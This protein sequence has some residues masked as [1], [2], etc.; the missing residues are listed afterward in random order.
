MKQLREAKQ[1]SQEAAAKRLGVSKNTIYRYEN[2]LQEPTRERLTKLAIIFNT[3]VDYIC[4]ISE[5]EPLVLYGLTPKQQ[6]IILDLI[7]NF[8]AEQNK[9]SE[10]ND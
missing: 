3:S 2:N 4:G 10:L 1:L 5:K 6:Q 8:G 9:G 7:F